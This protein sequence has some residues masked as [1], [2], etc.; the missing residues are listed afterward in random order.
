MRGEMGERVKFLS[1]SKSQRN[2]FKIAF[3]D[4]KGVVSFL[5]EAEKKFQTLKVYLRI[6]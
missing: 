4:Q 1:T 6:K 3:I 2:M 5:V